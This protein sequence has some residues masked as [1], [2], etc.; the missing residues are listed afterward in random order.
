MVSGTDGKKIKV[1]IS[2]P[3][4]SAEEFRARREQYANA[5]LPL[6]VNNIDTAIS[7]LYVD[8]LGYD[9]QEQNPRQEQIDRL[10]T[11]AERYA[12]ISIDNKNNEKDPDWQT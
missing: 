3:L 9:R 6:L 12:K 5:V 11:L 7:E 1:R 8:D 4:E 2:E 10:N